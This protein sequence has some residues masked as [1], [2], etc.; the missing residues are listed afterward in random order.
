MT[1]NELTKI[2][3]ALYGRT[4]QSQLADDLGVNSSQIRMWLSGKRSIRTTLSDDL[5]PII[6]RRKA[7]ID[8]IL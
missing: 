7:E 6:Q 4:W 3:T 8:A 2:G 1:T 5:A